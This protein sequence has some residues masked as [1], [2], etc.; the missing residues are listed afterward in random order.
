MFDHAVEQLEEMYGKIQNDQDIL[1][2]ESANSEKLTDEEVAKMII[3]AGSE[4]A[5][6]KTS[7][8]IVLKRINIEHNYANGSRWSVRFHRSL[9][10][11]Y[12]EQKQIFKTEAL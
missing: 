6:N 9:T 12:E 8:P 1:F 10:K 5:K 3:P 11:Y 4:G 7:Q 2:L